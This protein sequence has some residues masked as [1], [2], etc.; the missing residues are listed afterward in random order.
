MK[1]SSNNENITFDPSAE[2]VDKI[3]ALRYVLVKNEADGEIHVMLD[4]IQDRIEKR[5]E[6]EHYHRRIAK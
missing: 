6:D 1:D 3:I 4:E 2:V 5:K